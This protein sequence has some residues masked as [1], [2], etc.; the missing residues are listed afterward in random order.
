VKDPGPVHIMSG[1]RSS[2]GAGFPPSTSLV[3]Y[4]YHSV[5]PP[6][7]F[8]LNTYVILIKWINRMNLEPANSVSPETQGALDG[9]VL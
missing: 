4:Q 1:G 2:S 5:S 7:R 8:H 9:S 6:Y 3:L